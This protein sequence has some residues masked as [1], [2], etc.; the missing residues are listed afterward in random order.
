MDL[1]KQVWNSRIA[2]AWFTV[3]PFYHY[4][5]FCKVA[6]AGIFSKSNLFW[7]SGSILIDFGD[8]VVWIGSNP[9]FVKQK[10]LDLWRICV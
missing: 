8:F 5:L 6:R 3:L 2:I 10:E 1:T 7:L 4:F 9:G